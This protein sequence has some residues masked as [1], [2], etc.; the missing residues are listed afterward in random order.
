MP[1]GRRARVHRFVRDHL[2]LDVRVVPRSGRRPDKGFG[3]AKRLAVQGDR[4]FNEIVDTALVRSG[5]HQSLSRDS[6][7]NLVQALTMTAGVEGLV[8]ECGVYRGLSA[9]TLCSYLRQENDSFTGAGFHVFDSF[10]GI[11]EPTPADELEAGSRLGDLPRGKGILSASLA[12]VQ[13]ALKEFPGIGFHK[14]WIPASFVGAPEGPYRFVHLDVDL[15][16]PIRDSLEFFHPRLAPGGVIVCD[17]FGSLRWPGVE[18]AVRAFCAAGSV[19]VLP[20][21]S[22]QAVVFGRGR[23]LPTDR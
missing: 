18:V 10:E 13:E 20:L 2:G 21:A 9:Y 7:Y 8:A 5:Y 3:G 16:D 4:V 6:L 15:H 22:G 23:R 1:S 19:A 12:T 17:D 14:G 11:S